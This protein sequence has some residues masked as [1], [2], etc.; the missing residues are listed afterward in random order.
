VV[1]VFEIKGTAWENVHAYVI[2]ILAAD[3]LLLN[4]VETVDLQV[5]ERWVQWRGYLWASAG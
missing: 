5:T 4:L 3:S 1:P 2:S